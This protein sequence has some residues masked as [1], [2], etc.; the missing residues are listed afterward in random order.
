M[1]LDST[2]GR[3]RR[4]FTSDIVSIRREAPVCLCWGSLTSVCC[5]PGR[6]QG[7]AGDFIPEDPTGSENRS[8]AEEVS[9]FS[10]GIV[11]PSG[12]PLP[13]KLLSFLAAC[14]TL[15]TSSIH[16]AHHHL[17][18]FLLKPCKQP[19]VTDPLICLS[20]DSLWLH[21]QTDCWMMATWREQMQPCMPQTERRNRVGV[22]MRC[23]THLKPQKLSI[24]PAI[25][26]VSSAY[27][28]GDAM[29]AS[30]SAVCCF[31]PDHEG[32]SVA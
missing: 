19:T 6:T 21:A 28:I 3:R 29:H 9:N 2:V 11:G 5:T 32:A 30:T 12:R 1:W 13:L 25:S 7:P 18:L 23:W 16:Y 22:K 27:M 15:R 20:G 31:A 4:P 24:T 17:L 26:R 8:A 10:L 14:N